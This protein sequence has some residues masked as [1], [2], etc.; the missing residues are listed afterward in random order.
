MVPVDQMFIYFDLG[1]VILFFDNDQS[2]RQIAEVSQVSEELVRKVLI[3][4]GLQKRYETGQLSTKGAYDEFCRATKSSPDQDDLAHAASDMFTLNVRILPVITQ[5]KA[6]GYRLGI[7]S[8]TCEAHW[9]FV[10]RGRYKI[11][12]AL[13]D[14]T[15]LSYQVR[16]I[17]PAKSIYEEAIRLSKTDATNIFYTDDRRENVDAA[18]DLG[19]QAHL[20]ESASQLIDQ[21]HDTGIQINL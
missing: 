3:D 12:T 16:A 8:N 11:L 7:L 6:A 13:M 21:L 17:K 18:R 2:Y 9:D 14:V 5:L 4:D 20:F 1:N 10:G 15:V 19:I